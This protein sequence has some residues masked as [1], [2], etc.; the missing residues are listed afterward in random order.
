[1]PVFISAIGYALTAKVAVSSLAYAI[2]AF[3]VDYAATIW[4]GGMLLGSAAMSQSQARKAQR[5][6][7]EAYNASQVDRMHNVV[8][9]I[10]QRD[11]VMGRVRKAG[12]VFARASTGATKEKFC[13]AIAL[14]G[15]EIDGVETVYFNDQAVTLDGSGNVTS[16]PYMLTRKGTAIEPFAAGPTVTLGHTPVADTISATYTTGTGQDAV[17]TQLQ[18]SVVGTTATITTDGSTPYTG[19][20]SITYQYEDQVSKAQVR[21]YL[22]TADQTAD[23]DLQAL[24]PGDWT[25]DHRARGV[26]YLVCE[27]DYDETAFPSGLPSV[28]ALIRGA[29]LY[30]PRDASTAFSENPALMVRHLLTHPSFGKRTSITAAEDARIAAAANACDISTGYVVSG[31]T[32]TRELF[33]AGYVLPY[34]APAKDALDDLCQAMGGM[35]AY[36]GGQ[37]YLRAGVHTASVMTLTEADLAVVRRGSDGSEQQ[38]PIVIGAHKAR[39][40]KV[41][42]ITPRIWD[43]AQGYK[44]VALTPLAPAALIARDGAWLA[45]EVDMPAVTYSPQALHVAGII[46]RDDRDSLRVTLPFKLRAYPI[47]LFDTVALTLARY[48]WSAKEFIVLGYTWTHDGSIQL[49]LKETAAAIYQLDAAFD[50]QGYAANT[51]LPSPWDIDPP[52]N[53]A[54]TSGTADLLRQGDGTIVPRVKVAWDAITDQSL[55]FGGQVEVR[56]RLATEAGWHTVSVPAAETYV[57][58][59]GAKEGDVGY[60]QLRTRNSIAVSDWSLQIT[61]QVAGKS[62]APG[63]VTSLAATGIEHGIRISGILPSDPDLA[64]AEVW[65]GPD[66]NIAN[67]SRITW[68]LASS[69]DQLGLAA[70]DGTK[71]FWVRCVDTSGNLGDFVGPVSAVAGITATPGSVTGLSATAIIGGIRVSGTLPAEDDLAYVELWMGTTNVLGAASRITW[72]LAS[73]YDQLGLL[74]TDGARYFWARCVNTSGTAGAYVGPVSAT[75][76]QASSAQIAALAWNKVTDSGGRPADYADV[77]SSILA[78]SGTSIVMSNANLFKSSSGVGGV[79]IG[80]GGLTGKNSSGTS[81]FTIDGSTGNATL[82]GNLAVTGSAIINGSNFDGSVYQALRV[83]TLRATA[84]GVEAGTSAARGSG[85]IALGG[86]ASAGGDGVFGSTTGG[87]GYGVEGVAVAASGAGVLAYGSGGAYGLSVSGP[88]YTDNTTVVGNLNAKY[89]DGNVATAFAA[90]THNH[91]GVY[92]PAGGTAAS[93]VQISNSGHT[94]TFSGG[95]ASGAA[96]ATFSSANK[97]GT[98]TAN[99]WLA[100]VIDGT[101]YDIAA[102]PR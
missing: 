90:A 33:T 4:A 26:A 82:S 18:V 62:D 100:M 68:G 39:A 67:A 6:Q 53:I 99:I 1:M 66:S 8:T 69:Y 89:F 59:L 7:R 15:H 44:Q 47:E 12:T 36:A 11:L 63:D 28:S 83:N 57:Y 25:A 61:H 93:A 35:W 72:G 46:I 32:D 31:V 34:G 96:T 91:T 85:G 75:A 49:T 71:Y 56:Y 51:N 45:Q 65:M 19:D 9:T 13:L 17:T 3:L 64:Y 95:S 84:G 20:G 58:L 24:F 2:G 76:G 88:M 40:D 37:F 94:Y 81:T 21:I 52:A 87:S 43:G 79:F 16:E 98:S 80:A 50:P 86:Y 22:G 30:D 97:P 38:S 42:V 70:S 23:A 54:V 27:F 92:L 60:C 5:K 41:N 101:T 77:T 74:P 10:G 29:K 78:S 14:A 55:L 48:G 102:W 73:S